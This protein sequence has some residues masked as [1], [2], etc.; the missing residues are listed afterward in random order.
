MPSAEEAPTDG[1]FAAATHRQPGRREGTAFLLRVARGRSS[2]TSTESGTSNLPTSP[3]VDTSQ[4]APLVQKGIE[5]LNSTSE[6]TQFFNRD[7]SDA[8]QTTA[9]TALTRFIADPTDIPAQPAGLADGRPA[10]LCVMTAVQDAPVQTGAPPRPG[11]RRRVPP[12][13]WAF[14]LLPLA[15]EL[16]WVFWPAMNSFSL[17]FTEWN[18]VGAARA[19][20]VRELRAILSRPDLRHRA[21]QQ[22][23]LGDRV[24]RAV[25]GGRARARGGAQ[26]PG[27]GVGIYRSAIYLPMVFSLAVT[28]LFW[29]VMYQPGG[30]IDVGLGAI[31]LE[32]A[33]AAVARRTRTPRST[34]C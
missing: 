7:S 29:R 23:D 18:G 34:P 9:D 32:R 14:L 21:A 24:R 11:R 20:R 22:R 3:E 28:G 17:S 31:G 6:I 1:Y 5:L 8:L 15:V 19:R 33:A 4:F 12:L 2:A 13:V 27:R 25:G 10:G 30:P 26:P 16:F